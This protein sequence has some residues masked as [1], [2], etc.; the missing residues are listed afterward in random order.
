V[1]RVWSLAA[2]AALAL[3][4]ALVACSKAPRTSHEEAPVTPPVTRPIDAPA[5][6]DAAPSDAPAMIDA[7]AMIDAPV[8]VDAAV[9]PADAAVK[10]GG[11]LGKLGDVCARG[12]RGNRD[13]GSVSR[14]VLTCGA[15]LRCCYPCGVPGCDSVCKKTCPRVP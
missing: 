6:I 2:L 9:P 11:K 4:V 3:L 14:P 7:R 10:K 5:M 15:G 12:S 8:V 13:E 1:I